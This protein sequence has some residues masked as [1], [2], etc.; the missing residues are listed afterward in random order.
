MKSFLDSPQTSTGWNQT[1]CLNLQYMELC[2]KG[3]FEFHS[4]CPILSSLTFTFIDSL[5]LCDELW[6][7]T[8]GPESEHVKIDVLAIA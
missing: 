7:I 8:A 5:I 3:I 2:Y 6:V 1:F 4:F